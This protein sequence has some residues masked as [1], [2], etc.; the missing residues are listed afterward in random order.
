MHSENLGTYDRFAVFFVLSP[1]PS[2]PF[3]GGGERD[4]TTLPPFFPHYFS[5]GS[6]RGRI[7]F[8]PLARLTLCLVRT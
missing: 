2:S 7:P 3:F 8:P 4:S 6:G 1:P 5:V